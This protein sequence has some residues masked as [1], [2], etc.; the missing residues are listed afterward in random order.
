VGHGVVDV[1][2]AARKIGIPI[3]PPL[4]E[5]GMARFY[6]P[7]GGEPI[8]LGWDPGKPRPDLQVI[9]VTGRRV[10]IEVHASGAVLLVAPKRALRTGVYI[11]RVH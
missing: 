3:N 7:G 4:A 8:V 11:A 10:P 2:E 1:A 9:D 5:I 6:H